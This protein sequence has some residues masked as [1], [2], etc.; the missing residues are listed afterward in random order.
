MLEGDHDLIFF[1]RGEPLTEGH[2]EENDA[3]QHRAMEIAFR[4]VRPEEAT[5]QLLF[6]TNGLAES[7]TTSTTHGRAMTASA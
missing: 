1:D 7:S 6:A 5:N 4:F 3:C 2:A